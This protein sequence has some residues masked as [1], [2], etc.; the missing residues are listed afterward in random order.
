[1]AE[2]LRR[3]LDGKPVVAKPPSPVSRMLWRITARPV[4]ALGAVAGIMLGVTAVLLLARGAE[5]DRKREALGRAVERAALQLVEPIGG[6]GLEAT[7]REISALDPESSLAPFLIAVAA[8]KAPARPDDPVVARLADAEN[9]RLAGD[10]VRSLALLDPAFDDARTSPV[11]WALA[12]R[13]ARDEAVRAAL[14]PRL[15]RAC[16]AA[17][18]RPSLWAGLGH[19]LVLEKKP[20]EAAA[21]FARALASAP[22][23]GHLSF[24]EA[25]ALDRAGRAP[26]GLAAARRGGA[27]T[28]VRFGRYLDREKRRTDAWVVFREVLAAHGDRIDA[29]FHL[30]TSLAAAE[31]V[32]SAA[33]EYRQVLARDAAHAPALV[34]LAWIHAWVCGH[35]RCAAVR[36]SERAIELAAAALRADGGR[37]RAVLLTATRIAKHLNRR[38][39]LIAVIRD[40]VA[41]GR[42]GGRNTALLE[43]ALKELAAP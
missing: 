18:D 8:G 5:T 6:T 12:S 27:D 7:A 10:R 11:V 1:V 39:A 29:R 24:H 40:L 25:C 33:A 26:E 14:I 38:E 3:F 20:A 35:E 19:L 9:A 30:A 42:A 13:L 4:L 31:E 32:E 22:E 43:D 28:L 15:V 34:S 37:E 2:D 16:E 17:P 23:P 21:A 36:D 41:E